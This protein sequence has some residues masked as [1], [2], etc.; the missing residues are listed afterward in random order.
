M[1]LIIEGK[2]RSIYLVK[3]WTTQNGH[4]ARVQKCVWSALVKNL[5][6][7]LDDFYTGYVL[8]NPTDTKT[9]YD[10]DVDVHGGVTFGGELPEVEGI[11][12]GFDMAHI[13]DE[14]IPDPEKY[15]EEE[16]EKLANQML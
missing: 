16:C 9:Y 1:E 3:E 13:N 6:P 10:S 2:E 7:S 12:V 8:K 15:C 4:N 11:W 5:A 14:N